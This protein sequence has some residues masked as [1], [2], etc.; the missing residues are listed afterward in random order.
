VGR[1]V[2][3]R[4][5]FSLAIGDLIRIEGTP[6]NDGIYEVD[7]VAAGTI[8]TVE[9]T[10]LTQAAGGSYTITKIVSGLAN[11]DEVFSYDFDGNVQGGRAVSQP[12]FVK[13]KAIGASG[14]QYVETT[15]Q[16]IITGT[17]L[18]VTLVGQTERNY[19]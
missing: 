15:V 14:S 17:P 3:Y 19:V 12:T 8:T 18:T 5:P 1:A 2:L 6:T 4:H 16:S 13:A 10:I 11:A 9:Q 7:T